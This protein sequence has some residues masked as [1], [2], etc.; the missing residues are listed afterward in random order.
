[1]KVTLQEEIKIKRIRIKKIILMKQIHL[2]ERKNNIKVSL[3]MMI[4]K[5]YKKVI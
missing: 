5:I 3:M 4:K 2:K 1:M